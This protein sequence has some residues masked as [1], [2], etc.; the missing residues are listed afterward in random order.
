MAMNPD[1]AGDQGQGA[2]PDAAGDGGGDP[3]QALQ[4]IGEGLTMVVESLTQ[5]KAPQEIIAP[6]QA[7]LEAFTAGYQ[8]IQ[9]GG[10][11]E[12]QGAS[13]MEAGGAQVAPSGNNQMRG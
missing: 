3:M 12:P 9:G 1:M 5:Q 2:N 11:Q 8:A 6:F 13:T 7:S 4:Q 10:G